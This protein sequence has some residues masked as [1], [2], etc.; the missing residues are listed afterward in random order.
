MRKLVVPFGVFLLGIRSTG[1]PRI[2]LPRLAAVNQRHRL[3][4]D[5]PDDLVVRD[6][7]AAQR[8]QS[9]SVLLIPLMLAGAAA[10]A[11]LGGGIWWSL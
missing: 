9:R 5:S 4:A 10:V 8:A 1:C 3:A 7:A 2:S 6:A 11:L